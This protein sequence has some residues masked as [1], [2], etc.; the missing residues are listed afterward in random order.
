M[1]ND[2]RHGGVLQRA[3]GIVHS[4]KKKNHRPGLRNRSGVLYLAANGIDPRTF[5]VRRKG[6]IL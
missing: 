2:N 1:F 3:A 6:A 5:V 4:V